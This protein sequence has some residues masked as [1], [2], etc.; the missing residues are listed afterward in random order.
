MTERPLVLVFAKPPVPGSVKTRL[1]PPLTPEEA[2][3]LHLAALRDV[4]DRVRTAGLPFELHLAGL[5][6]SAPGG[7][8]H[9]WDRATL[10]EDLGDPPVRAQRG[11]DLGARLTHAFGDAFGRGYSRVLVLGSDHPTLPPETLAAGSDRL[12]DH[13]AVFGP[14]R[15]GGYYLVGLHRR[16]WPAT[17]GLFEGIGWS[18]DRVM[19]QSLE[20]AG[21]LGLDVS[22]LREWYDVDRPDDLRRLARDAAPGSASARFLKRLAERGG[23]P[24]P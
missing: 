19:D 11:A 17:A 16:S 9:G 21:K 20:R 3:E 14:S 13:D 8:P 2:A 10:A 6:S 18:S 12:G 15:D 23:W 7:D 24:V 5:V 1:V 22:L 4:V